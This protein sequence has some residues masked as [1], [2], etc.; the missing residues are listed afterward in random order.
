MPDGS[1]LLMGGDDG[2]NRMNDVWWSDDSGGTWAQLPDAGWAGRAYHTSVVMP[3]GGILVMGGTGTTGSRNDMWRS[4]D[5]GWTWIQ[6]PDAGW[7]NRQNPHGGHAAGRERHSHGRLARQ[8]LLF[9]RHLA[10]PTR[11]LD[12]AEPNTHLYDPREPTR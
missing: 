6:L 8:R 7:L 2:S 5:G 10:V 3:D 4:D 12:G 11:R 9:K 1:I